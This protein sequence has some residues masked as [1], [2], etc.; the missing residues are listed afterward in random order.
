MK[1]KTTNKLVVT[2]A[3]A[4]GVVLIERTT[5]YTYKLV[6]Y[7]KDYRKK[8]AEKIIVDKE[9]TKIESKSRSAVA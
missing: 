6:T 8:K 7:Y 2:T 4:A 3:I 1:T 5:F 9:L